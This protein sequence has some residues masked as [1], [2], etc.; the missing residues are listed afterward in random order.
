MAEQLRAQVEDRLLA[1]P[2]GEV[3][4]HEREDSLAE[5]N[6]EQQEDDTPE[7]LEIAGDDVGVDGH[8]YELRPERTQKGC[9]HDGDERDHHPRA[10]RHQVLH[11][12]PQEPPVK[13]RLFRFGIGAAV[14]QLCTTVCCS[15]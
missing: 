5:Q 11:D 4:I 12:P 9:R 6:D 14:A 13:R 10:V 2:L 7:P 1:Y 15:G 3:G 8:L